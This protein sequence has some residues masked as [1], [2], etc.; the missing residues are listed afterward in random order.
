MRAAIQLAGSPGRGTLCHRMLSPMSKCYAGGVLLPFPERLKKKG[1]SRT[2]RYLIGLAVLIWI[3]VEGTTEHSIFAWISERYNPIKFVVRGVAVATNW[4]ASNPLLF[5]L[6][7]GLS[8]CLAVILFAQFSRDRKPRLEI[9]SVWNGDQVGH[10]Q[11]VFGVLTDSNKSA[12]VELRVYGDKL[13]HRQWPVIVEGNRWR[14]KC[15]FGSSEDPA[16]SPFKLVA[17]APKQELGDRIAEL[18]S[19]AELSEIVSVVLSTPRSS[20]GSP[21]G[22]AIR[23]QVGEHNR[24]HIGPG[25]GNEAVLLGIQN[26]EQG[27]QYKCHGMRAELTFTH[28]HSKETF[29]L[30]GWFASIDNGRIAA[31]PVDSL[32]LDS[33]EQSRTWLILYVTSHLHET[34]QYRF[35][36]PGPPVMGGPPSDG[37]WTVNVTE[38]NRLSY[39]KWEVS[40]AIRSDGQDRLDLIEQI[41]AD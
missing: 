37:D 12:P 4:A 19:D 10:Q 28:S 29:R 14:A 8:Y 31:M 6:V 27:Y 40:I 3:V 15:Q 18:P 13:W 41:Q 7:L 35:P 33:K 16:G 2:S 36:A 20:A 30:P 11:E 26:V 9:V 21:N 1:A 32:M 23:L 38:V 22:S 34:G 39:G 24:V 5:A 25:I 17:M